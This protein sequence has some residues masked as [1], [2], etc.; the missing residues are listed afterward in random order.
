MIFPKAFELKEIRELKNLTFQALAEQLKL[1]TQ[2]VSRA[3]KGLSISANTF[4][5]LMAWLRANG[6]VRKLDIARNE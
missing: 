2:S 1:N 4:A 5:L 6:G 3:E